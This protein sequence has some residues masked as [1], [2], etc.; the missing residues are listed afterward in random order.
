[1]GSCGELGRSGHRPARFGRGSGP[2]ARGQDS[3]PFEMTSCPSSD[4]MSMR[5]GAG[6]LESPPWP[7]PPQAATRKQKLHKN[8]KRTRRPYL[9]ACAP[10]CRM[11]IRVSRS[12]LRGHRLGRGLL[13]VHLGRAA[14][15]E[16]LRDVELADLVLHRLVLQ[17]VG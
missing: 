6:T 8:E 7:A 5:A 1:P 9:D 15:L 4:S 14:F 10:S 17:A 3:G 13:D 16:E 11:V 2:S 12:C